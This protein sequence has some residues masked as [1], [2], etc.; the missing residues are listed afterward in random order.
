MEIDFLLIEH[1]DSVIREPEIHLIDRAKEH[2]P[3]A[4][5]F[6]RTREGGF[7]IVQRSIE[8]SYSASVS[9]PC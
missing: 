1:H 5:R 7:Q 9:S 6:R 2:D 4:G 3:Q 8:P